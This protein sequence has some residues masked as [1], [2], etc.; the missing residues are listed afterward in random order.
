MYWWLK[1]HAGGA[2]HWGLCPLCFR[3]IQKI[4][5]S[6]K[7]SFSKTMEL[8]WLSQNHKIQEKLIWPFSGDNKRKKYLNNNPE[9]HNKFLYHFD[10]VV[11]QAPIL[12]KYLSGTFTVVSTTRIYQITF[13]MIIPYSAKSVDI[14]VVQ[15]NCLACPFCKISWQSD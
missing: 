9:F 3:Q 11:S 1:R 4:L 13:G 10:M 12:P 6:I 5:F 2:G 8:P 15:E 7:G 14:W